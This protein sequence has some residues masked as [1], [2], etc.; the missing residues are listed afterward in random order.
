MYV[1]CVAVGD[2]TH[3]Q[4]EVY[5]DTYVHCGHFISKCS[6]CRGGGG[7]T[8]TSSMFVVR[9]PCPRVCEWSSQFRFVSIAHILCYGAAILW[10]H[11]VPTSAISLCSNESH[12]T[13]KDEIDGKCD[14]Q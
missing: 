14:Q 1:R 2:W 3:S 5:P 8:V 10:F 11:C 6:V 12:F 4:S 13:T 9:F 7:P